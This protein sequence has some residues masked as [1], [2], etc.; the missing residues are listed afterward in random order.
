MLN[1]AKIEARDRAGL[2]PSELAAQAEKEAMVKQIQT[3]AKG[4]RA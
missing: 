4:H 1:G 3:F 2:T